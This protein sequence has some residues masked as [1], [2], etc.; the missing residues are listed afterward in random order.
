[1]KLILISPS[2][3]TDSETRIVTE[4]FEHGLETYHLRKPTMRTKEMR[5]YLER[6]P[7][8]FHNRIIIHSHHNLANRYPLK[9]VHLTRLHLKKKF[10]TWFRLKF[11]QLK[12][13][14]LTISTTFHKIAHVYGNKQKFNY[15]FIGTIFDRVEGKFNAGYAEYSLRSAIQKSASPLIARGGTS[16]DNIAICREIGFGGMVFY[17]A[18]WN[19]EQPVDAFCRILTRF[20]ELNIPIE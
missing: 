11:L 9:G 1:M 12:R 4:L 6:I 13:P 19:D 10:S 16:I 14:D 15:V 2:K 20:R 17:T 18:I 7:A 3:T 5:Q 8:H